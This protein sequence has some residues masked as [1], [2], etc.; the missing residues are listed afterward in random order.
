MKKVKFK[1]QHLKLLADV[2][3][4]VSLYLKLRDKYANS[5]LLESSDY[6]GNENSFSYICCNPIS[7]FALKDMHLKIML[8][9]GSESNED[10]HAPDQAV[11]KLKRYLET[12]EIEH[13][14]YRFITNGLLIHFPFNS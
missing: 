5:I 1:S 11:D 7:S 4:P 13:S 10:L 3:T 6:H 8:P 14:Q 2:V 9:D 12:F